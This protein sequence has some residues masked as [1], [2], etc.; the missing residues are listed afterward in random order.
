MTF[1]KQLTRDSHRGNL[2]SSQQFLKHGV[3][4][5]YQLKTLN[6]SIFKW[7]RS[8]QTNTNNKW[9]WSENTISR[10]F[11]AEKYFSQRFEWFIINE[12]SI[13][14]RN[15]WIWSSSR[16][17]WEI[18]RIAYFCI[19][20]RFN[21]EERINIL[22]SVHR[23]ERKEDLINHHVNFNDMDLRGSFRRWNLFL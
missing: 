1:S 5:P 4:Y 19:E 9:I 6:Y 3:I 14:L 21:C 10:F 20:V 8:N 22:N 11:N 2:I 12:F 18:T 15:E 13:L 7:T 17:S 23:N 16:W